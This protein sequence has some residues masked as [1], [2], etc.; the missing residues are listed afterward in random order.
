MGLALTGLAFAYTGART[1]TWWAAPAYW[2]SLL[3]MVAPVSLRLASAAACRTE[4]LGLVVSLGLALYLVKVFHSPV[5]FTFSDEFGHWRTATDLLQTGR[6]YSENPLISVSALYPGLEIITTALVNL[7]GL[8]IF[9]TSVIL[10]GLSRLI[11]VFSLFGLYEQIS[12]SAR[13]AGIAAL[14]YMANPNFVLFGAQFA[15]ESL[16]LPL[17]ALVLYTAACR[18]TSPAGGRTELTLAILLGTGAVVV[19]HHLTSY[20]LIG[21]LGVWTAVG[22]V[23]GRLSGQQTNPSGAFLVAVVASLGWLV[24]VATLTIGYLAPN[25]GGGLSE[26][27]RLISG[28]AISRQLFRS[29]SGQEA[30]LWE[31]FMGYASVGLVL[32]ALPFGLLQVW[33]GHRNS[34][35]ALTMG[36][37]ALA[38]PVSLALRLTPRGAETSNRS[39]EFLFIAVAFVLA[40]GIHALWLSSSSSR[41]RSMAFAVWATIIFVGGLIV[42]WG[43][44]ARL[45]GPYLLSADTRSIEGQGLAAA[46]W[47]PDHLGQGNRIATD[48]INRLLLGSY[49]AQRPVTLYADRINT[50]LLFLAEEF[51]PPEQKILANGRLR[52]LVVDRRLSSGLPTV[53][54]YFERGE[55]ETYRRTTPISSAALEKFDHLEMVSRVFDSGDIAIYDVGAHA[56]AP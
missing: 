5:D 4:R 25:L 43:P 21:F 19:T 16:S 44:W 32:L 6:L 39:S 1:E 27:V 7:S 30:P 9:E 46:A 49:G 36:L 45:P 15:Y 53:G 10:L 20:A 38:Y 22:F 12:G 41:I 17:A 24:Y 11:L 35:L 55:P 33:R 47:A 23:C 8:S 40:V 2:A 13:V 18:A 29:F 54:V 42:G 51:G 31:Q 37:G 14:L 48:R 50:P 34:Q 28:E 26:L 52:Y 3:T 56:H